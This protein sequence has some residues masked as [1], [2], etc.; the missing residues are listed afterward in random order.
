M[1][2]AHEGW[3]D[4]IQFVCFC[5]E[6]EGD[7]AGHPAGHAPGGEEAV[8][9]G[10]QALDR[11][12]DA[13][14]VLGG[15]TIGGRDGVEGNSVSTGVADSIKVGLPELNLSQNPRKSLHLSRSLCLTLSVSGVLSPESESESKSK[16]ESE[17]EP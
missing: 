4:V 7:A 6:Q 2:T 17:H 13:A 3:I 14:H 16:S 9:R 8:L 12:D 15:A 11:R 5:E 10:N 1:D